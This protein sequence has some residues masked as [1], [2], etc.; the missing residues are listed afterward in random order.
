M[1]LLL[2]SAILQFEFVLVVSC[3]TKTEVLFLEEVLGPPVLGSEMPG[4]APDISHY[5]GEVLSQGSRSFP[6]KSS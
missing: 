2:T 3:G 5:S 4:N 6:W 1:H